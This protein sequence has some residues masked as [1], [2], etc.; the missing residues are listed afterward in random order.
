MSYSLGFDGGGTK[1][2]CVLIDSS[3]NVIG[4]GHGG[5][6]NPLRCGY[7]VAFASLRDAAAAA[8]ASSNIQPT[9]ISGVHAGLAGAGRRN[10]ARRVFVFLAQEFPSALAQVSTDCEIALEAAA[11]SG[12][13]VV[14]IAGTGSIAY[15]RNVAGE[16]ARAGGHG[17]W[18]GD[19]GSAFEIGRRSVSA[20]ARVRD[21]DAPA[22]V[23]P[24]MISAA[25]KCPDWDEL[26]LRIMKNP[27]DVFPK[28]FPVV[29]AAANSEDSAAREIMFASAIGL[30]N[31]AMVVIRR[32]G[33]KDDV[34]PLVKCGGVFGHCQ[35]LDS[36]LDS[37]LASGALRAKISRLEISPALG[38]ARMAARLT[39]SS[40]Q[41]AIHGA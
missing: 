23:L 16:T 36:L 25:L 22:S 32:L 28:L 11:G 8:L 27:D 9:D 20:V 24:E 39:E 3:G 2:H 38:A 29:V 4:E 13:G 1:T 31:L 12:P 6:A 18:I 26:L 35:M 17:P 19:E 40:S 21:L 41:A 10:V 30:S 33:M 34:F 7:D 5:P 14:L 15:G 37:V